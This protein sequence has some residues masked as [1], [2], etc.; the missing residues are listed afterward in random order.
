MKVQCP[1]C[2]K[3]TEYKNNFIENRLSFG[4]ITVCRNCGGGFWVTSPIQKWAYK[5]LSFSVGI[6]GIIN[7]IKNSLAKKVG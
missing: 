3:E 2:Y 1:L 7:K 6:K 5:H 4:F